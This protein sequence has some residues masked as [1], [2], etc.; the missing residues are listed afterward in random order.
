MAYGGITADLSLVFSDSSHHTTATTDTSHSNLTEDAPPSDLASADPGIKSVSFVVDGF[1][2]RGQ[3]MTPQAAKGM[4][5][6][7]KVWSHSSTSS[8]RSSSR[9]VSGPG[10]PDVMV[11]HVAFTMW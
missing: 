1:G 11:S 4:Q 7:A 2:G 3:M 9:P 5:A 10:G 6:V 8:A